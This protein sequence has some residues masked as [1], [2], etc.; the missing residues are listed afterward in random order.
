MA[1]GYGYKPVRAVKPKA[2]ARPK[3]KKKSRKSK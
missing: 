3:V 2:K 1:R